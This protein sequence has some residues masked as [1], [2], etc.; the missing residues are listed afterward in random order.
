MILYKAVD[1]AGNY[2]SSTKYRQVAFQSFQ[3][4]GPGN[5][6]IKGALVRAN[7]LNWLL[8]LNLSQIN[9]LRQN[10]FVI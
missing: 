9:K 8:H 6:I 10:E 2:S 3:P 7:S 4:R 1:H 5:F